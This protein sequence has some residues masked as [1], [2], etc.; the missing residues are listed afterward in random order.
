MVKLLLLLTL[1]LFGGATWGFAKGE[2]FLEIF[3]FVYCL[4]L[5]TWQL[6]KRRSLIRKCGKPYQVRIC[7]KG[8]GRRIGFGRL[9]LSSWSDPCDVKLDMVDDSRYRLTIR[10][11]YYPVNSISIEFECSESR[12]SQLRGAM[13]C[14]RTATNSVSRSSVVK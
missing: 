13:A 10:I 5:V 1:F 8:F 7:P 6:L 3:L 9:D 4:W 2:W 12:A 11:H 14:Y